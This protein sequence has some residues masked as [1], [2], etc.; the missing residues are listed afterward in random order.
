MIVEAF[1][2]LQDHQEEL[3]QGSTSIS[4]SSTSLNQL[5]EAQGT[6][7]LHLN[8][9]C[10]QNHF[11]G[12]EFLKLFKL[13]KINLSAFSLGALLSVLRVPRHKDSFLTALAEHAFLYF[14]S[15]QFRHERC[16][17]Q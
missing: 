17:L 14:S 4:K 7:F 5:L 8:F 11:I 15:L 12:L 6:V 9:A 1:D 16:I 3:S 2:T 13:R 10:R